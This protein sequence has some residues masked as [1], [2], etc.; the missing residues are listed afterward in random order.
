MQKQVKY[1]LYIWYTFFSAISWANNSQDS[2]LISND[3]LNILIN[4]TAQSIQLSHAEAKEYLDWATR[5]NRIWK[6]SDSSIRQRLLHLVH[7]SKTPI[8]T[9]R[10]YFQNID[11]SKFDFDTVQVVHTDTLGIYWLSD[12]LFFIDTVPLKKSPVVTNTTIVMKSIEPDSSMIK[13]MDSIP[14]L[15]FYFDS[16]ITVKDTIT[17]TKVDFT[18]LKKNN[19][20]LHQIKNGIVSPPI[21][22]FDSEKTVEFGRD[23]IHIIIKEITEIL[24]A[25]S[26][27]GLNII[28]GSRFIDS[29]QKSV[30]T[31]LEYTWNRDS[32]P[33]FINDPRGSSTPFWLSSKKSE[34]FRYWLH[35]TK[36]DSV[37]VWLGNPAKYN[38]IM[39]LEESVQV[40]RMDILPSDDLMFTTKKADKTPA[41]IKPLI[42]IPTLWDL[43]FDGSFSINQNYITYWAQGGESSFAGMI[44]L[45]GLAKY[46]NKETN[47]QW[48]NSGRI[49]YGSV[50]SKDKG[51]RVSTDIIE[52]NSQYNKKIANKFD[53]SSVFYFKTQIS[54]GYNYP[55]DSVAVSKFLNPGTFTI[56]LG[57]EYNPLEKT[58]INFSPLSYKSTFVLDTNNIDQTIH[59]V[60]KGSKSKQEIGG[61]LL[62]KNDLKLFENLKIANTLRLFSNYAENPQ[63]VDVDWEM[64]MERRISWIFSIKLNIHLI[65]DD[66]IRFPVETPEGLEIKAPRTQ[67][68]QFLGLSISLNL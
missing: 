24:L 68:N 16:L 61:Q 49:R 22:P 3:S 44:D 57:A 45:A 20:K 17:E 4:D 29:L 58:I 23:S 13:M 67:F 64:T 39:Q 66:D 32:I 62:I 10:K 52:I 51:L 48:I 55:N 28:P 34:L 56:G 59:G 36:K 30:E 25:D 47:S 38:V 26:S 12:S 1:T 40:Q 33:I 54:K 21:L 37:T 42:E 8:D 46:S 2:L 6:N 7:H 53:F 41:P 15:Q 31:I 35:N 11:Y 60:E 43:G 50:W 27:T 14:V 65:Y 5:E 63:N 19:I 9:L 18:Y